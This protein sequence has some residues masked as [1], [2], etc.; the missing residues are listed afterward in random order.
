MGDQQETE[1]LINEE[2]LLL[3]QYLRK[4]KYGFLESQ[5]SSH[6][7]QLAGVILLR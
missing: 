6:D 5:V 1:K 7:L 2:V 4:E 3:A